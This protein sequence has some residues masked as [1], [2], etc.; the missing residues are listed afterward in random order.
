MLT[1]QRVTAM[2]HLDKCTIRFPFYHTSLL[3]CG[4]HPALLFPLFPPLDVLP[5]SPL[6]V[7]ILPAQ[8]ATYPACAIQCSLFASAKLSSGFFF[9]FDALFLG[10]RDANE[11]STSFHDLVFYRRRGHP[12]SLL[13]HYRI[14]TFSPVH[15]LLSR[16]CSKYAVKGYGTYGRMPFCLVRLEAFVL[17]HEWHFF[18]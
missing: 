16:L 6:V 9:L 8:L 5:C 17:G 11:C 1:R 14:R 10:C 7:V 15:D 3:T 4:V 12:V 18:M 2:G 13:S